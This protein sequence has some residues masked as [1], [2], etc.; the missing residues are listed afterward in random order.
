MSLVR[1][2]A[3]LH[4][5]HTNM[6]IKR[7]FDNAYQHDEY[8]IKQ[9]NSVVHKKDTTFILGDVTMETKHNYDLLDRLN[10]KKTV[11]LGNHDMPNHVP[12]LLK[13]V[14]KVSGMMKKKF[15][16]ERVTAFL[17]HCPIHTR[18]MDYRV[19]INIHGHIH[20]YVVLLPNS[21]PDKRYICVSC[22]QID[23]T[24]KLL[25]ELM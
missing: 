9:W 1:F 2:I 22:E 6:A 16:Q 23:Y 21:K 17:T 25:S 5:G 14:T 19:G 4:L 10:G 15:K 11:I 24:P 8:I 3:D 20:E 18:E 12:E 7:G 13:H